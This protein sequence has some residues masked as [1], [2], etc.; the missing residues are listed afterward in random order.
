MTPIRKGGT[1]RSSQVRPGDIRNAISNVLPAKAGLP[2]REAEMVRRSLIVLVLLTLG[3]AALVAGRA[4]I[5]AAGHENCALSSTA[6]SS[7]LG[8]AVITSGSVDC[9]T[10]KNVIRFSI[11]LTADGSL[12]ETSE[13]TCHKAKTCWSYV[14]EN[15]PPGD[16]RYCSTVSAR[17]G[18]HSLAPVTLCE[19]DVAL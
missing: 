1:G 11:T 4:E 2:W 14:F 3:L 9:T 16:Q 7:Y 8:T 13:R 15:D 17:V 18:S 12:V 19:E 6:P 10:A 5:A